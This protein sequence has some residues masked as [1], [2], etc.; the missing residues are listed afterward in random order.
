VR[1]KQS[2]R[3]RQGGN[4]ACASLS[5]GQ[6]GASWGEIRRPASPLGRWISRG[7]CATC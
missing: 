7:S 3:E 1:P 4:N 5:V 2:E 6:P